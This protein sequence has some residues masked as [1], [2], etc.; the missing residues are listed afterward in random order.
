MVYAAVKES[1]FT[2]VEI[3]VRQKKKKVLVTGGTGFV[4]SALV[5]HLLAAGYDVRIMARRGRNRFL[6]AGLNIEVVDGDITRPGIVDKA[7]QGCDIVFDVASVYTFYPFWVRD[8]R[9]LEKTNVQG[10]VNL[11]KASMRHGVK[12]F[13][14]TSSIATIGKRQDGQPSDETTGFDPRNASHYARSKYK[15]EQ[16]VLKY[17]G[18]GLPAVILNPAIILGQR[19]H[20]PTPSGDVIV[21]FLN[22]SYPGYFD[23][24]WSVCD[25]DDVARAHV[26][27]IEKGKPGERYILCNEKHFSL[28]K[29]FDILEDISGIKAPGLR[30]PDPLL[31]A[32]VYWDELF[33]YFILRRPPLL[34]VEGVRFCK[35]SISYRSAKA[36]RELGYVSTPVE[37]S[38]AKAVAWYRKNGYVEPKGF[39][40][41][42]ARGPA[43]VGNFMAMIGM[44]RLADKLNPGSFIFFLT[45]KSLEL[46]QKAGLKANEDGWRRITQSYLR[47]EPSKFSLAAFGL[48]Y[49]S[50][51]PG[52]PIRSQSPA[53]DR[54]TGRLAVFLRDFPPLHFR[55]KWDRFS[56]RQ[57]RTET[58]D[59]VR[60]KYEDKGDLVSLEPCFDERLSS[61]TKLDSKTQKRLL[62]LIIDAYNS[63]RLLDD[64]KRPLE[65]RR[66]LK[67]RFKRDW[68]AMSSELRRE[69]IDF[70]ERVLGATFIHFE[71]MDA[72]V[73]SEDGSRLKPPHFVKRKHP[74]FGLLNVTCR[75]TKDLQEADL[76][77]QMHHV[78]ID[79][80]PVQEVLGELKRRWGT[81]RKFLFPRPGCSQGEQPELV[82]TA[83]GPKGIY[84]KYL[85][86]DFRA[87][88]G[89]RR[90]LNARGTR[91]FRGNITAAALLIW[92]LA[93]NRAFEDIKFAVPVDLPAEGKRERTLGFVFIRPCRYLDRTRPDRGFFNFQRA[94][95]EQLLATKKRVSD[96][97]RLLESMALAPPFLYEAAARILPGAEQE[98]AGT[99]GITVIKKADF[100]V[101]PISD[102]HADGFI[103][104]SNFSLPSAGGGRV[105]VVSL[106]GPKEKIEAYAEAL[107][108]LMHRAVS[109]DELYF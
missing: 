46:L 6:L 97:Y 98:F 76:W 99:V 106:K 34:P 59:L 101:A 7:V 29:I 5:R 55:L 69:A 85:F 40:R 25:I 74:G 93:E 24:L 2:G 49:G 16:E 57:I 36:A 20:K 26:A 103:A 42:K 92:K 95:N 90:R 80:V 62:Q 68:A 67:S 10:T 9:A 47:T 21:K 31:F 4:G 96:S 86:I 75:F 105:G 83:A 15:A 38:L 77:F 107:K 81:R 30:I 12:R 53:E 64:R 35:M 71:I 1:F 87:F 54:L 19:D 41:L 73:L 51:R 60:A 91:A 72:N 18:R 65:L 33:S 52:E 109:D 37:E 27:A 102:V 13:I 45:V 66:E 58:I 14:H 104:F 22:R 79:G 11:L 39:F 108:D 48:D 100:F 78:P 56:A 84:H 70:S 28:K 89:F 44:D 3:P 32:F 88:L 50:D 17:C 82:S 63:T 61:R 94:F 23:T 8:A 43:V